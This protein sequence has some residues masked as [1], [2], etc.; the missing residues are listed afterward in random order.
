MAL[1]QHSMP[2]FDQAINLLRPLDKMDVLTKHAGLGTTTKNYATFETEGDEE[3]VDEEDENYEDEDEEDSSD[4]PEEGFV[5]FE[6]K[7]YDEVEAIYVQA[8][9]DVRRDLKTRKKERGFVKHNKKPPKGRGRGRNKKGRGKG[10]QDRPRDHYMKGTEAELASRTRCWKCQELGHI[11]RDCPNRSQ[12]SSSPKKTTFIV[13][14]PQAQHALSYPVSFPR[15]PAELPQPNLRSIRGIFVGLRCRAFE[16]LVDTAAEDAVMGSHALRSLREELATVGLQP[17]RVTGQQSIPC[18]GIG[19]DAI[20]EQVVDVPTCIAGLLGIIRFSVV[21]DSATLCA[22]PLVPVSYLEAVGA[23][24]DLGSNTYSTQEGYST[25]LRRLPSGHRAI[26]ILAFGLTPWVLPREHRVGGKDPF[27]LDPEVAEHPPSPPSPPDVPSSQRFSTGGKGR[28]R[29]SFG[30][31][32][33]GPP[34]TV[35]APSGPTRVTANEFVPPL[36]TELGY[37]ELEPASAMSVDY[38]FDEEGGAVTSEG[39]ESPPMLPVIPE[40]S[41]FPVTGPPT[42]PDERVLSFHTRESDGLTAHEIDGS[43][44]TFEVEDDQSAPARTRLPS[45]STTRSD[46]GTGKGDDAPW[47]EDRESETPTV[48]PETDHPKGKGKKGFRSTYAKARSR[49]E[50][51]IPKGKGVGKGPAPGPWKIKGKGKSDELKSIS[52]W[53]RKADGT[54]T[55]MEVRSGELKYL[56]TPFHMTSWPSPRLTIHRMVFGHYANGVNFTVRDTWVESTIPPSGGPS[57]VRLPEMP[58]WWYGTVMFFEGEAP[59]EDARVA[60]ARI[61]AHHCTTTEML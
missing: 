59:V 12:P 31:I 16:G 14:K 22:P 25:T 44:E 18:A 21:T 15:P 58:D 45:S 55:L 56:P 29:G 35:P 42:N 48:D 11:S 40:T 13:H 39:G 49:A 7:E 10:R 52:F 19:G 36:P 30:G 27:Q 51:Y 1:S 24:I 61:R 6:D 23:T 60:A 9:N 54:K 4:A 3:N 41:V 38:E 2:T 8:Y 32:A 5:Y 57:H 26:N 17:L 43:E 20:I 37:E 34:P 33:V 46:K 28:G 47:E 53:L 50:P